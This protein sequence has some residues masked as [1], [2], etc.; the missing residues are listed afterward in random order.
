[1]GRGARV[2]A[3]L[4]TGLRD[5]RGVC[6]LALST[7]LLAVGAGACGSTS[8]TSSSNSSASGGGTMFQLAEITKAVNEIK[9]KLGPTTQLIGV[10]VT[11]VAAVFDYRVGNGDEARSITWDVTAGMQPPEALDTSTLKPLSPR[12]FS[13]TTVDPSVVP[14]LVA[15][16]PARAGNPKFHVTSLGLSRQPAGLG[17]SWQVVDTDNPALGVLTAKP[18]GTGLK[19]LG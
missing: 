2:V 6:A 16:A 4:G 13:I 7:A 9:A 1:M 10:N 19:K 12:A 18:D 15:S 5:L 17:L 14:K 11:S 3:M 8:S